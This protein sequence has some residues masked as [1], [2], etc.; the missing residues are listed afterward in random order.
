MTKI[1]IY[2]H[3]T[4]E[5]EVRDMNEAELAQFE[6][7]IAASAEKKAVAEAKEAAKN[8]ILE[9]LGITEDEAKILGIIADKS[10]PI[11]S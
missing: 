3:E 5:Q 11:F 6:A 1:G 7:E 8:A 10:L 4:G 2:N 9:R